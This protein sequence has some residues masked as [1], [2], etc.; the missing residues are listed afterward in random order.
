MAKNLDLDFTKLHL[1]YMIYE[2]YKISLNSRKLLYPHLINIFIDDPDKDSVS[3]RDFE[4]DPY[5]SQSLNDDEEEKSPADSNNVDEEV[6]DPT[7]DFFP[8]K[9]EEDIDDLKLKDELKESENANETQLNET[10]GQMETEQNQFETDRSGAI[11]EDLGEGEMDDE[12]INDE[13]MIKIAETCLMRISNELK[14]KNVTIHDLF[15]ENIMSEDIEGQKIELLAPLHFIEGIRKLGI[16]D[17]TEL[18]IACLVNLLTRQELDD[19]ILIDELEIL[20]DT[21]KLRE[22]I[23]DMHE[24]SGVSAAQETEEKEEEEETPS[25]SKKKKRAINFDNLGHR[26]I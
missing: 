8:S 18:D 13:E 11:D 16:N 6:K 12:Y 20:K 22:L 7:H 5:F 10:E 26:S 1:E 9:K 17:F 15:N 2:M 14:E 19:L 4:D 24:K 21:T 23:A 3:G 25:P